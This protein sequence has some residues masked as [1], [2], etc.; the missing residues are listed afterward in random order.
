MKMSITHRLFLAIL[1]AAALAVA[2]MVLI[3]QWNLSRG[4]KRYV[5]SVE[6][7]G[8]SRLV[9]GLEELY[10]TERSWLTL[11]QD[12]HL[13]RQLVRDSMLQEDG[14]PRGE[15]SWLRIPPP[16]DRQPPSFHQRQLPSHIM[17]G[18]LDRLMVLDS[19]QQVIVGSGK[20]STSSELTPLHV[21]GQIVGYLALLPYDNLPNPHQKRFLKEQKKSVAMVAVVIV[22]VAA[23]AAMILAKRL[24]R[25]IRSLAAA[26][27]DLAK[28]NYRVRVQAESADELGRLAN[29]FNALATKLEKNE[30]L[31]RQWVAD[32]SHELRTPLAVLLG[33]IEAVQ[34]GVRKLT[35]DTVRSLHGEV[36]RLGRLVD[37]LYQL[38]LADMEALTY[39]L[40]PVDLSNVIKNAVAA[41]M[42]EFEAQEISVTINLSPNRSATVHGDE[43]RLFQ[44]FS[45]LL[46]NT[47]KYTDRGGS[48]A[49][50][51][52][53]SHGKAIIDFQDSLPGVPEPELP[54]L[55]D[56]LYR[57]EQ[58][59]SR[60]AGGAG[61]GLAI[62]RSIAEAHGGT[63]NA[64]HSPFG[65]VWIH[66]VLP[67]VEGT[68]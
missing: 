19:D 18:L 64:Q 36:T 6:K 48:L 5:A 16:P 56:R 31:R 53:S 12:H 47:L 14:F 34:D 63:I 4:F 32:I 49:I 38:S 57:V 35:P 24:V 39:N 11:Q 45:N 37:D 58:S 10:G 8:V 13:W 40:S 50:T 65:G 60:T 55:F 2:S 33:E 42:A 3:M 22:L 54:R 15:G 43:T 41:F 62:S 30:Q 46:N 20:L 44:L 68:E 9:T 25:P 27:D 17:G 23:A 21:D 61:L 1:I 29:D 66:V 67:L 59:R 52:T 28:G 51:V 26:T 7:V